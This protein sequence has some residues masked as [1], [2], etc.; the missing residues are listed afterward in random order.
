MLVIDK[1]T[2]GRHGNK[3][4][5]FNTLMQLS[6]ILNQEARTDHWDGYDNF[7][8]TC[9]L[10]THPIQAGE[11][12]FNDLIYDNEEQLK[13]KYSSGDWKL[14][15]LSLCGPFFRIT[16]RDPREFI[17][18]VHKVQLNAGED[19]TVGIHIRGGD[20]RGA[21]GMNCREIHPP[22]YYI[23]SIDF[24]LNEF[25]NQVKFYL[26]TDDPDLN[27][28]T[29]ANTIRHL[30]SKGVG[31]Y[32]DPSSHYVKDF[33]IL[34]ECDVLI[35]GSSTFALAAGMVGKHKKVIHSKNFVE[36]F[37]NEDQKW[38]SSFGNGMFFHDMNHMKSDYYNVW[39]L[40]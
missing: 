32:H 2:R 24:V 9:D 39:K 18:S 19:V 15:S 26:C 11:I 12:S 38:Y 14:H 13:Q 7:E 5:H 1:Q 37:K 6:S 29:Y 22:E 28:P 27:Y 25:N 33:C 31:F 16:K 4:F 36:Q 34:S 40:L 10:L 21:D 17:K 30:A 3:V 23:E 35:A 20:T 8:K